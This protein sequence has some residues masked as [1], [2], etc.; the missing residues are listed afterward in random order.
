MDQTCPGCEARGPH[1]QKEC[2][3]TLTHQ[4]YLLTLGMTNFMVALQK[5]L[6]KAAAEITA[7]LN[8]EAK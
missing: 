8:R 6:T 7:I 4:G 3:T 5:E 2:A 1:F